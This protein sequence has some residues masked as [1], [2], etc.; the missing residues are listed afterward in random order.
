MC[1][2]ETVTPGITEKEMR[3]VYLTNVSRFHNCMRIS[4]PVGNA[5]YDSRTF[6]GMLRK[7]STFLKD[8]MYMKNYLHIII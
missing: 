1:G 7:I 6:E 8:Y 5:L 4:I 3:Y 2:I